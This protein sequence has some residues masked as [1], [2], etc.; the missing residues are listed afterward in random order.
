MKL[1]EGMSLGRVVKLLQQHKGG[2]KDKDGN[3][4]PPDAESAAAE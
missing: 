1:I 4:V 3:P 2:L